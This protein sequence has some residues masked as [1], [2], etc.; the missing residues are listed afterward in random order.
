M[1]N[2]CLVIGGS[3]FIG[4][5]VVRQLN[6]AGKQVIV[7]G[8]KSEAAVLMPEECDYV[9]GDYSDKDRLKSLLHT[10]CDVIHLAYSSVPKTSFEDPISDI[11]AN[12]PPSVGLLKECVSAGVRRLVLVSSGGAVYGPSL[13]QPISEEYPTNPISPYG[14]TKL[15]IDRYAAM[16]YQMYDLPVVV[17]RPGN[18]FGEEQ[19]PGKGQGFIANAINAIVKNQE[20]EIY[21]QQ[22]TIRD[23]IHV[24]DVALGILAALNRGEPGRIYN[25]GTGLGTSNSGILRLLEPLARSLGGEIRVKITEPRQ[26]DVAYSV[27]N[28][29]Q[30]MNASGWRPSIGLRQGLESVWNYHLKSSF[31]G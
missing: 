19:Y 26:F 23:Y 17:V 30:L 1:K 24:Q 10:G 7:L 6:L 12:I 14:I 2:H 5:Q 28:S 13:H 15:T 9:C 18:A 3:G 16:Y 27:L 8:R 11:L 22:G 20:V 31:A 25:I 4:R 21:G 29:T